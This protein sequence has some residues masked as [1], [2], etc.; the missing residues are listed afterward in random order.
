MARSAAVRPL[1]GLHA[2]LGPRHWRHPAHNPIAIRKETVVS[3]LERT[4]QRQSR[5]P[6][7]R[8]TEV[9][10]QLRTAIVQGT[11]RP[12][13]RLIETELAERLEV[14]RTPVRE[15]ML[16][17]AGDGLITNH[18]RGWV[19]REHS[20]D[21]IREVFE[22]RA[23]LEGFAARLAA[24]RATDEELVMIAKIHQDYIDSVSN[25]ARGELLEH[26]DAFH[27]AVIAAAR[28]QLL[29]ERIHANSQYYFIHRIAG[30]LSDEEVR[31]SIEG[32]GRLVDALS[33]RDPAAAE[34]AA[35]TAVFEGLAKVLARLPH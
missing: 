30:F 27:D 32:H 5:S 14:S 10:E 25:T 9:Y 24:D 18:R 2:K 33:D 23:A 11:I 35:R 19:V 15:S 21:E 26:N 3:P 6:H 34:S 31:N 12:N 1:A 28:N 13:E 16:R 4:S 20:S 22:V 17:L 8:T 29:A 7:T